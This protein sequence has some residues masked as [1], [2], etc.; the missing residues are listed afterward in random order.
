MEAEVFRWIFKKYFVK[1]HEN[2]SS[3]SHVVPCMT[4]VIIAFRNFANALEKL[5][6]KL[7]FRER[8]H[9]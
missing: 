6:L 8:R 9:N 5:S 3:G 2:P 1:F 4:K 7:Q